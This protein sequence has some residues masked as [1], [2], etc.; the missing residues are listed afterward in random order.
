MIEAL[1]RN[2]PQLDT[3]RLVATLEGSRAIDIGLGPP[4]SFGQSE[5]QGVHKVWGTQLDE[6][7]RYQPIDLQ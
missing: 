4:V 1:K 2:G 3:E 5:H 7:G 6:N